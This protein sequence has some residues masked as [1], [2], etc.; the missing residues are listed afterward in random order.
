MLDGW[1]KHLQNQRGY[2]RVSRRAQRR[3]HYFFHLDQAGRNQAA[4]H[5]PAVYLGNASGSVWFN[6][7][8]DNTAEPEIDGIGDVLSGRCQVCK[9]LCRLVNMSRILSRGGIGDFGC[10]AFL[11]AFLGEF[12]WRVVAEG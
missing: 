4:I 8:A 11:R 9:Y 3:N 2:P 10:V 7:N 5:E 1:G 6:G 12:L